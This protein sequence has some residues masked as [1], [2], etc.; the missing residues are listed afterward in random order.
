[1]QIK[2]YAN[3]RTLIGHSSLDLSAADLR[4][5]QQLLLRLIE[6]Y[7]EIEPHL[8]D[9]YGKLRSDVPIFINGRNPRLISPS[10]DI[11]LEPE[12]VISIFS[13]IASGRMNVEVMRSAT[14]DEKE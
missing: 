11:F 2:F 13:P 10:L 6:L 4:S 5:L 3:M 1:M 9:A 12:D 7:P 14:P 8:L